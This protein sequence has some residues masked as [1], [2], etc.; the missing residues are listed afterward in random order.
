MDEITCPNCNV[1]VDIEELRRNSLCCPTC[2]QDLSDSGE[3]ARWSERDQE[4]DP[5]EDE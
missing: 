4:K 2:G 3:L 1:D 5:D